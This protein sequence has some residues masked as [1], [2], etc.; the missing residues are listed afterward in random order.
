M[1]AETLRRAILLDHAVSDRASQG[2]LSG[3]L[4]RVV[5]DSRP[6]PR[7]F[8]EVAEPWQWDRVNAILPAVEH[9]AGFRRDYSGPLNFYFGYA[10]GHD[11][12]SFIARLFNWLLGYSR[13]RLKVYA[14]AADA[15]QARLIRDAM[16]SERL[17][18]PW[19]KRRVQIM[20]KAAWGSGGQLEILAA[21]AASAQGKLPD[22]I[23]LDEVT[24]WHSKDFFDALYSARN[25]R[26]ECVTVVT[27]NAGIKGSWQWELRE[28]AR[29]SSN[30]LYF[31]Q[32]ERQQLASWMNADRIAEDRKLLT[33]T[34]ADRLL[35]N[36]WIDPG[37]ESGFCLLDEALAC[38]G[39]VGEGSKR[40]RYFAAVDY[41]PRRDRTALALLRRD[42]DGDPLALADLQCWHRPGGEVQIEE[43]ERW[44]EAVHAT[45]PQTVFVFDEYQMLSTIQKYEK[46]GY[47]IERFAPRG[48]AANYELA[49]NLRSLIASRRIRWGEFTGPTLPH[50]TSPL[51]AADSFE[52]ELSQLL[53]RVT[54]SGY[55]FDHRSGKHDDRAV[56]VG[57]AALFAVSAPP[58]A[59]FA[60]PT[61]I[62]QPHFDFKSP[63]RRTFFGVR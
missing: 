20:L 5:I 17:L 47:R 37:E 40:S 39:G 35:D 28:A 1:N 36:R 23:V 16:A 32:P 25:K 38:R 44:I 63:P 11:K 7:R 53:L 27:T 24:H 10:K 45:R 12:T 58:L 54:P 14:A 46:Q 41:G 33:P 29:Q 49:A 22:V 50:T 18:N 43:V 60:P 19:L 2:G 3:Y 62:P 9:V 42:G 55:R 21:D 51:P 6:E 15:D 26:P 57:M 52:S 56:A 59:E 48:G 61:P 30:W 34:E 31:E 8:G 13:R 4:N